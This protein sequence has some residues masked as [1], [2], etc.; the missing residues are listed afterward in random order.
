MSWTVKRRSGTEK[1]KGKR[2]ERK[3]NHENLPPAVPLQA[4]HAEAAK[5]ENRRGSYRCLGIKK[6]GLGKSVICHI[7]APLGV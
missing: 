4:Q 2:K 3:R 5:K 1:K 6:V 7:S